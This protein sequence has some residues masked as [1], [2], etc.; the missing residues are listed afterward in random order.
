MRVLR[1]FGIAV[2]TGL[3]GMFLAFFAAEWLTRLYHV[4]NFEGER[5]YAVV[6]LFAPAGFVAGFV[7]GF[8][9]G[10][11]FRA[12]AFLGYLK[13]QTLSILATLCL[14][15]SVSGFAW[16]NS[17]HTPHI[18]GKNVALEFEVKIPPAV[19]LPAELNS[20]T[21]GVSLYASRR[22]YRGAEIDFNAIKKSDASTI[23]PG[24]AILRS[25]SA[26]RELLA[27]YGEVSK[28]AQVINLVDLAPTPR[29][30]TENWSD[31]IAA[32]HYADLKEIPE[33]ERMAA[34][35]RVR[36]ASE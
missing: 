17:D 19:Q 32:T 36:V 26:D 18:N 31:W 1:A 28:P 33:A 2:I 7:I 8:V 27:W 24:S 11:F 5:A 15:G 30:P 25:R 29:A 34:R 21:L 22:D 20:H 14:I 10:I 9:G 13:A 35:W 23:V 12:P 3:A 4:S 16:L 6:F